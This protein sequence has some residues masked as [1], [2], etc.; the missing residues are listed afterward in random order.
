MATSDSTPTKP[1]SKCKQEYP[2]TS[3]YF[4]R[5]KHAPSGLRSDCRFCNKAKSLK[6]RNEHLEMSR[7]RELAYNATH[8]TERAQYQRSLREANPG[9]DGRHRNKQKRDAWRVAWYAANPDKV[10][11]YKRKDS[12]KRRA[13]KIGSPGSY[14]AADIRLQIK[15]QTDK[16]GRLHCWWCSEVITNN[17][18]HVDHRITLSRGG[19]NAPENLCISCP[20]CNLSKN[21]KLPQEWNGRLL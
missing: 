4:Y 19:S 15:S 18:Y 5:D 12:A 1:C 6:F 11:S 7:A 16:R 13:Y 10:T 9:Y 3:E 17:Q 2:F 20:K 14:T 8:R 21:N